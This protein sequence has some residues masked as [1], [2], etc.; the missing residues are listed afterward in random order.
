MFS[1]RNRDS[2]VAKGCI[3]SSFSRRCVVGFLLEYAE[4]VGMM[5][6]KRDSEGYR[7]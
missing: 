5:M 1:I 7:I 4:G 6:L 2:N 3:E